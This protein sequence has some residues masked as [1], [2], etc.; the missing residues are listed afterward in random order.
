ML[1]S[2]LQLQATTDEMHGK[3]DDIEERAKIMCPKSAPLLD[4][5]RRL[6]NVK[7]KF[8]E[9]S[10]NIEYIEKAQTKLID[11]ISKYYVPSAEAVNYAC[12]TSGRM[13]IDKFVVP[14]LSV[15]EDIPMQISQP[16]SDQDEQKTDAKKKKL[17]KKAGK[18]LQHNYPQFNEIEE[19]EFN[20][21]D[22]R[23]RNGIN[24]DTIRTFHK[25]VYDYFYGPNPNTILMRSEMP[26]HGFITKPDICSNVLKL[27]GR[28]KQ[29]RTKNIIE[30]TC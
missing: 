15:P 1:N 17:A 6:N 5:C 24:L 8:N 26:K 7:Q 12:N 11:A 22:Q 14:Q 21:I 25:Q 4:L 10:A 29:D 2:I 9:I 20:A 13:H 23:D 18:T 16:D 19:G 3:L 30:C 28:I 27:L